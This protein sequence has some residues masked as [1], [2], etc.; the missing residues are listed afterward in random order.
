[1]EKTPIIVSIIAIELKLRNG[2]FL[3][4]HLE[5]LVALYSYIFVMLSKNIILRVCSHQSDSSGIHWNRPYS[6]GIRNPLDFSCSPL[7]NKK[8]S[9]FR[10][11]PWNP[12]DSVSPSE[13]KRAKYK[14]STNPL[15][16]SCPSIDLQKT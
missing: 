6:S 11:P 10:I 3:I 14:Q 5:S 12:L 15:D 1:L 2:S 13:K 9:G 16:F 8:Y 4:S 7:Q